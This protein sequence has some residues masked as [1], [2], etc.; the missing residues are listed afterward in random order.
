[1]DESFYVIPSATPPPSEQ[2]LQSE[3]EILKQELEATKA[4]LSSTE[5]VLKSRMEQERALRDSIL[6]VKREVR[7][8]I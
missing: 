3:N 6:L 2:K 1:M 8:C 7:V 4:K 5:K